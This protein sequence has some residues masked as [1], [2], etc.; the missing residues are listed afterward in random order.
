M[1]T[2]S[3]IGALVALIVAIFLILK[4][5]SPA[6]GMLVGALVGGL[7][8]GADLSQTVSLMIGGAQGITTAVMRI[9]AAG[10]L[11]GVLIESGAANSIAETITN[12]L[13]ETRALLA[14]AL[15]TMILTAVGVF[16]DVAVI[17]VSPIALALARRSD[18]SKAAILLAMIGGGKAGNIM[19]PN[20]NA[21]AAADTFHLPL[22]SVIMAGIIPAL[23]G[24][25]LTYFLAKRLI[26]KGS[27]VT[28][29]EVIVLETQNLPSFL[30][31][32]VAPLVAILL[33]ALRPLFDIK[34]DPLI[35]LPL[36]GLIGAL[37][38]GKL[39]NINSYAING[40]S[41]MTP[42]AIM[43]LG[44]G[45]LA[46]IIANSGLKEVLIQGLEHSGLPSYILA[47]ISGALMSL[48]TASTTAGTAVASN[49]FSSTLLELGI[50]SLAG[51]AMI[52]AGATVFDHMPHGSFFHATG[53]SVNMDI[54]ERL[55]LI[56]YESAVGLMMTIV[57]TLIFGV[58]K[59]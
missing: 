49:V 8:G 51:A 12:K 15:A 16:V 7:I 14:L 55:K 10:V 23:F 31:A 50:S 42:V 28:D 27:K 43:L 32:L 29:K 4:K 37:C 35:A 48:A 53:G 33:L 21:I 36:G 46:G 6:Y 39:R 26:N 58:F 40:L 5:V 18:L 57:A 11:A 34:V 3:A 25:I 2:V 9:L 30:T 59:F 20:P 47:P 44:T 19:S 22:T 38:M 17:T 24:L 45:A 1:T 56:P 52:H 13:G 54:K 41:K